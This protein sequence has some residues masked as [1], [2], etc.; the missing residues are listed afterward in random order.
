MRTGPA[1]HEPRSLA[2]QL[3][4]SQHIVPPKRLPTEYDLVRIELELDVLFRGA[5][6]QPKDEDSGVFDC[7]R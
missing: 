5:N 3:E 4:Q 1:F 2:E 6:R 7:I